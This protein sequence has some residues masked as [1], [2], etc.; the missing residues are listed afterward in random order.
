MNCGMRV[1]PAHC[2]NLPPQCVPVHSF[3]DF[4]YNSPIL[5]FP[6]RFLFYY[7]ILF[8]EMRGSEISAKKRGGKRKNEQERD[9]RTGQVYNAQKACI[10]FPPLSLFHALHIP[11]RFIFVGF[12]KTINPLELYNGISLL[13]ID[14]YIAYTRLR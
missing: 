5:F 6:R 13:F 9:T 8:S 2:D 4:P 14:S 3:L 1:H 12:K 11:W 10:L 7:L